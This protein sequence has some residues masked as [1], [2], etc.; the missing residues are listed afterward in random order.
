MSFVF[1]VRAVNTR[2]FF[3]AKLSLKV[4]YQYLYMDIYY[5]LCFSRLILF[6]FIRKSGGFQGFYHH[7]QQPHLLLFCH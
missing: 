7:L 4:L 3:Y 2:I 5:R 6:I 1:N